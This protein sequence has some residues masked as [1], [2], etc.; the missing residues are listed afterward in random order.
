[1]ATLL[2]LWEVQC[3][4]TNL[5]WAIFIYLWNCGHDCLKPT[6]SYSLPPY[7]SYNCSLLPVATARAVKLHKLP[8]PIIIRLVAMLR[9]GFW[10]SLSKG[11]ST[12]APPPTCLTAEMERVKIIGYHYF[13]L[14]VEE[15]N[16]AIENIIKGLSEIPHMATLCQNKCFSVMPVSAAVFLAL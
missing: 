9:V 13:H 8:V 15:W 2:D 14:P 16:E 7:S 10:W 3:K 11:L 5:F 1:M 12:N 4:S 6:S